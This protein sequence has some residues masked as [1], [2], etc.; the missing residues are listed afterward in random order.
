[1]CGNTTTFGQLFQKNLIQNFSQL[2]INSHDRKNL[3]KEEVISHNMTTH[4][5]FH[6]QQNP[7]IS[8]Q[9]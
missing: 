8:S 9:P 7:P 4:E 3:P 1:M 2:L 5:K 6:L